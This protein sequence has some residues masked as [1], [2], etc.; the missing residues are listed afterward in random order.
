MKKVLLAL[1]DTEYNTIESYI[2]KN[3]I[4][5][6]IDEFIIDCVSKEIYEENNK[7]QN[8]TEIKINDLENEINAIKKLLFTNICNKQKC[9]K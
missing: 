7:K 5:I 1:S 9:K 2:R 4:L 8:N 3:D 6:D